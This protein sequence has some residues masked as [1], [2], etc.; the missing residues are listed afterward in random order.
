MRIMRLHLDGE[1]MESIVSKVIDQLKEHERQQEVNAKQI[2]VGRDR[3]I[4]FI[5]GL[6]G[7]Q[8]GPTSELSKADNTFIKNHSSRVKGMYCN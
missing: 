4:Q 5:L 6:F 1:P 8:S 2:F 3:D 7:I